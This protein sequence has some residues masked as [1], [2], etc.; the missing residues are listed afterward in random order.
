VRHP[1]HAAAGL[2]PRQR[3]LLGGEEVEALPDRSLVWKRSRRRAM[4]RAMSAG[5]SSPAA[6]QLPV[7][8][9]Q[10]PL[11]RL[12]VLAGDARAH[13]LAPVVELLLELV[14]DDLA[15]LLDD[16]DLLQPLGEVPHA[17]GVQRPGH[18]DLVDAQPD[19][20]G[21]R[22][23]DA[24]RVE[25]LAHVEVGLAGGDD[26]EPRPGAVHHHPVQ[27]V[28]P[29]VGHRGVDLPAL[30][31]VF[32]VQRRVGPP[33]GKAARRHGEVGGSRVST[34]R[35]STTTPAEVST[36]SAMARMPIQQPEKRDIA[37]PCRPRSRN[38][39]TP[40]GFSTGIIAGGEDVVALVRDGGG[41]GAV[42]VAHH[43]QHPAVARGAG[44]VAVLE[45]VHAAVGARAPCRTTWRRRRRAWRR[46]EV[47]L[48]RAPDGGRRELL[49]DARLEVDA[50]PGKLLLGLPQRLVEVAERRAAVARDEAR[51]VQPRGRVAL[52]CSIGSRTSAWMPD[53]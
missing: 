38:S 9:R 20:R 12:V 17:L 46:E 1:L 23:V 53:R 2:R 4:T 43:G 15:L 52:C 28:G 36:V 45:H 39:C 26:A 30:E 24:E 22:R 5:V 16:Q 51:G 49:V 44:R 40:A 6:G 13:V 33:D 11:A 31:P 32:L 27:P 37:Q 29:G 8:A 7:A 47:D 35:G 25:R 19:L 14:L 21:E 42:V 18:A 34:R 41:L 48:L 3:R 50:V 10:L